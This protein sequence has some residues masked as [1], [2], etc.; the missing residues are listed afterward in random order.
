MYVLLYLISKIHDYA[1]IYESQNSYTRINQKLSV[2]L[3]SGVESL[4]YKCDFQ[5]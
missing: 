1:R 3:T 4:S 5:F 2:S